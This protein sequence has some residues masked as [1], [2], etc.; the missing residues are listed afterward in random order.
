VVL[1]GLMV[2]ETDFQEW[3]GEALIKLH[4]ED[5]TLVGY[6]ESILHEDTYLPHEKTCAVLE[7]LS[8]S[9]EEDLT[10]FGETLTTRWNAVE[11]AKRARIEEE[12]KRKQEAERQKAMQVQQQHQQKERDAKQRASAL[13]MSKEERQKRREL[14][15]RYGYQ[16]ETTDENGDIVLTE[17]A[18]DEQDAPLAVETNE[19]AKRVAQE[20]QAQREKAKEK[21]L[22]QVV[23][24]KEALLK[25]QQE[26]EKR[27]R[28]TEKREKRRL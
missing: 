24:D 6:V 15:E 10:E 28:K 22:Q 5:D 7:F 8:A 9:T 14:L 12:R 13:R 18:R 16:I 11:A 4:L 26:K 3:L 20:A 27:K 19:N 21:H 23:R 1:A 25:Q 2:E 17:N